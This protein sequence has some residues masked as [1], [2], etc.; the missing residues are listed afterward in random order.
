MNGISALRVI[1]GAE[2]RAMRNR[3]LKGN[4]TRLVALVIVLLLAIPFL[5][6]G[7]FTVGA[8]AGHF[9]P[10]SVDPLLSAAFTGLSLLMLLIGF[11]TVIASLFVGRDLLQLVVAPVRTRD[12]FVARL[13]TAM[14]ANILISGVLL[15]AVL[16]LGAGAGA[17]LI[18]FPVALLLIAVQ[19]LVVT[20]GRFGPYLAG[21]AHRLAA[22][23]MARACSHRDCERV[24]RC[25]AC[26]GAGHGAAGGDP[27]SDGGAPVRADAAGRAWSFR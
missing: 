23:H 15:A 21:S 24:G 16:G 3:L 22:D 6:G 13:V 25:R 8:T 10:F 20:P 27:R 11:P 7:T 18:Y 4:R 26:V 14:S 1:V 9:L 12:I 17:P 2:L 19:V 5:G